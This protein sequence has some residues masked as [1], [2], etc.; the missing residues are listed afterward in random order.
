MHCLQEFRGINIMSAELVISN[1]PNL[2]S[3]LNQLKN[4][5]LNGLSPKS[6]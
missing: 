4:L 1:Q 6:D 3:K 2:M 5:K